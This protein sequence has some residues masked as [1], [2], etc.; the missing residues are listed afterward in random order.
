MRKVETPPKSE[1]VSKITR[2][3]PANI[4]GFVDGMITLRMAVKF[5]LPKD[6]AALKRLGGLASR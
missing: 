5:E 1:I 4:A 2:A 3:I 6:F